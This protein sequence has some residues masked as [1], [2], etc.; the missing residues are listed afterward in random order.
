M[1]DEAATPPK[2]A[3][4]T[5][6]PSVGKLLPVKVIVSPLSEVLVTG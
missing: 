5:K 1:T 4:A 6:L 3:L 2:V